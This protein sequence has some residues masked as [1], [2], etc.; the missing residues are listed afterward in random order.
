MKP[1]PLGNEYHTMTCG[2]SGILYALEI[3]QGREEPWQGQKELS[4]KGK[5]VDLLLHLTRPIRA[6]QKLFSLTLASM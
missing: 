6:L 1:W 5:T 2:T 3:V 4:D